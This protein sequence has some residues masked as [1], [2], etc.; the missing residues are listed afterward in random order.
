MRHARRVSCESSQGNV[1]ES[2]EQNVWQDV[3]P[4]FTRCKTCRRQ[5]SRIR[6][7]TSSNS[8][9]LRQPTNKQQKYLCDWAI[10]ASAEKQVFCRFWRYYTFCRNLTNGAPPRQIQQVFHSHVR[11]STLLLLWLRLHDIN[12]NNIIFIN[13]HTIPIWCD[14]RIVQ[15]STGDMCKAVIRPP[16]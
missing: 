3:F 7:S 14:V 4:P 12:N 5:F 1:L 9:H 2:R 8:L 10:G 13:R 15:P 11:I 6:K 16:C